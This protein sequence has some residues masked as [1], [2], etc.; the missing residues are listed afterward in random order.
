MTPEQ[1]NLVQES[2]EKVAPISEQAAAIFYGKLFELDPSLKPMFKGDIEEQG[3]KLM[4]MLGTAVRSLDN[5]EGLVPVVQ[6][7]GV[8]HV[9]YGVK[10]S[11]YATVGTALLDTLA[12]GLGEDFTPEVKEAWTVVYGVLSSTMIAAADEA[13]NAKA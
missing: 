7:L 4:T 2:F 12:A 11:H 6:K 1:K 8:R 9:G 5:L 3:R 13:M 10:T